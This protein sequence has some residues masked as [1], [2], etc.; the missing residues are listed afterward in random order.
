MSV[1]T[2]QRQVNLRNIALPASH[3]GWGFLLEPILLGMLVAPSVAG[4]WLG[5]AALGA[6]LSQQPLKLALGD[7][8]K[9]RRYTRTIWAKRFSVLFCGTALAAFVL[10]IVSAQHPFWLPL[11]VAAPLALVQLY[12]DAQNRGREFVS[13]FFGAAA[14][15]SVATAIALAGGWPMAFALTLWAILFTRGLVSIVYVRAKLRFE[16]GQDID[17]KLILGIHTLGLLAIAALATIGL[18]PWLSTLAMAALLI[19]AIIGLLPNKKP[20]APKTVGFQEMGYGLL[21]VILTAI[22]YSF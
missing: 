21:T 17:A 11:L 16:R 7:L 9:R 8:R 6:F 1:N 15:G 20:V 18:A 14:L 12:Y 4:F 13:E 2:A 5:I 22:G 10:A 3:G 19:R